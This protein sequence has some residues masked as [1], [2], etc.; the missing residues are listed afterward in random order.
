MTEQDTTRP[1]DD[2]R[3]EEIDEDPVPDPTDKQ[4]PSDDDPEAD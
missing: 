2:D 3:N 1:R 4:R